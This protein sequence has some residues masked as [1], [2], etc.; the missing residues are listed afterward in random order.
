V[1]TFIGAYVSVRFD[2]CC[3]GKKSV[4]GIGERDDVDDDDDDE[5]DSPNAHVRVCR[6][7]HV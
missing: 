3:S 1:G 5:I 2:S 7:T 6:R 4:G